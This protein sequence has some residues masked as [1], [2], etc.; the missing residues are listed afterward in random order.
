MQHIQR[1]ETLPAG[2]LEDY[3]PILASK[4]FWAAVLTA[5]AGLIPAAAPHLMA[6]Q[7]AALAQAIAV[8]VG[9]G[10]TIISRVAA[11]KKIG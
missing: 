10:L 11:E 6:G 9:A 4:T 8:I 1:Q 3:K 7:V 5:V 2:G